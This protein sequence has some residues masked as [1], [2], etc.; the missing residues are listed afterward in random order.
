MGY[1]GFNFRIQLKINGALQNNINN[2]N[3]NLNQEANNNNNNQIEN[4]DQNQNAENQEQQQQAAPV[5][6]EHWNPME[7]DRAAEDLTWDRVWI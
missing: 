3:V 1:V 4:E 7:W 5:N 6:D 2:N